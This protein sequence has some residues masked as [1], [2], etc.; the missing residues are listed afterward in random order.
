[1]HAVQALLAE[2]ARGYAFEL[3]DADEAWF[4]GFKPV[5]GLPGRVWALE[6]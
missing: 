2:L 6:S 4:Q 3:E 1:M 5:N